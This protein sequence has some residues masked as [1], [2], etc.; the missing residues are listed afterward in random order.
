MIPKGYFLP[1]FKVMEVVLGECVKPLPDLLQLLVQF[2]M[3]N[4]TKPGSGGPPRGIF[5][6]SALFG[7]DGSE[8]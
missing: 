4:E 6:K 3:E 7:V 5:F 1:G 8:S 2:A